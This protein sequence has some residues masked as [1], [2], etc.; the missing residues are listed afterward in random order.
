MNAGNAKS[1][2]FEIEI[3][4]PLLNHVFFFFF[5]SFLLSVGMGWDGVGEE[6]EME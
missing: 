1:V 2:K 5:R 4:N 6:G 3:I